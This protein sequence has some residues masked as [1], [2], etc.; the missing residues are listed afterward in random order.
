MAVEL[1]VKKAARGKRMACVSR[2]IVS[3]A[4][5]SQYLCTLRSE[6]PLTD[7]KITELVS[8]AA[9]L[10]NIVLN[11]KAAKVAVSLNDMGNDGSVLNTWVRAK[12]VKA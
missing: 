3:I 5:P 10:H 11:C 8:N 6:T 12:V 4:V 9:T 7:T 1:K 2:I